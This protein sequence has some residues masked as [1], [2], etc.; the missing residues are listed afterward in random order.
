M[1]GAIKAQQETRRMF[2]LI[3]ESRGINFEF[4][5]IIACMIKTGFFRII[6]VLGLLL[7]GVSTQSADAKARLISLHQFPEETSRINISRGSVVKITNDYAIPLYNLNIIKVST[8]TRMLK[9]DEFQS[10]QAFDLEFA[11]EGIY[12]ICYSSH[13]ESESVKEDCLQVNVEAQLK[14]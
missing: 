5:R 11:R 10:G 6:L 14:A 13:P 3:N 9:V 2:F 1:V 4:H 8:G 12:N 7:L